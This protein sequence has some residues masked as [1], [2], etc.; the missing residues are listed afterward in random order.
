M[1]RRSNTNYLNN[2]DLLI[3]IHK[4]K[5]SFCEFEDS[6][7]KNFDAIVHDLHALTNDEICQ[8]L[9]NMTVDEFIANTKKTKIHKMKKENPDCELSEEDIL[10][11]DLV[12]RYMTF[13]HI[14]ADLNWPEDKEK[15]KPSDGYI[16]VNFPPYQHVSLQNGVPRVVGFSHRRNDEFDLEAGNITPKLGYMF[17]LLVEKISKKGNW[18][19]YTYIDEMKS[20]ALLQLSQVGLQFD[21]SRGQI[22]NPFAFYTTIVNNAFKRVLNIEKKN[23][24]IRD[25]LIEIAGQNPSFS[26]QMENHVAN[27][28]QLNTDNSSLQAPTKRK[29]NAK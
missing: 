10:T 21:E 16:K 25:D 8:E 28:D 19:N 11:G 4:S 27:N 6:K 5:T 18:R 15:K 20:S 24:D 14:P 2:R 29:K 23:R 3:E 22:P 9:Y 26:R 1:A 12:F 13:D 7:Y 17:M